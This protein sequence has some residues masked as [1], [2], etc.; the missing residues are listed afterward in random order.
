MTNRNPSK[1]ATV[2]LDSEGKFPEP[3]ITIWEPR[4]YPVLLRYLSQGYSC[5]RK[6]LINSDVEVLKA[7][8]VQEFQNINDPEAYASAIKTIKKKRYER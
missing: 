8:D 1:L 5:P 3:L 7:P 2:F 6:V 4:A